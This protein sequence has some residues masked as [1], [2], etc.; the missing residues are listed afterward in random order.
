[1]INLTQSIVLHQ[2]TKYFGRSRASF[3]CLRGCEWSVCLVGVMEVNAICD[4]SYAVTNVGL[5]DSRLTGDALLTS[6]AGR[7][8][9]TSVTQD[10]DWAS[11]KRA[12]SN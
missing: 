11:H 6:E 5:T 7:V 2:E 10:R 12:S 8:S 4:P 1:M 3:G 9:P